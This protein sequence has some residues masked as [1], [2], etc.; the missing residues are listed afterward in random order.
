MFALEAVRF[1]LK[2][3][4]CTNG[5]S[6]TMSDARPRIG[7]FERPTD[8]TP[9][10]P[11]PVPSGKTDAAAATG[12]TSEKLKEREAQLG[13][14]ASAA[15]AQAKPLNAFEEA[16]KLVGLTRE[17]AARIAAD[18]VDHGFYE[19]D[20][21]I[22]EKAKGRFRTRAYADTRRLYA[23]YE[24]TR[25]QYAATME[26]DKWRFLL[27]GSLAEWKGAKFEFPELTTSREAADK[28]FQARLNAVDNLGDPI[29]RLLFEKLEKFDQKIQVALR[30]GSVE[31]F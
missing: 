30:E 6:Q 14:E 23:H 27:A 16:L 31:N 8:P 17:E 13:A 21:T 28:M 3:K 19:E 11:V 1:L 9:P 7:S 5:E 29:I 4:S 10:P 22:T 2:S 20:V 24:V 15:E 26:E 18:Y 12:P 25:P